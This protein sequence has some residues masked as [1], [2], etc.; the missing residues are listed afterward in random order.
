MLKTIYFVL[1]CTLFMEMYV[2]IY[3]YLIQNHKKCNELFIY[4]FKIYFKYSQNK[5]INTHFYMC[6][7]IF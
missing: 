4:F 1:H 5:K 6:M 3:C 2:Y 7:Y